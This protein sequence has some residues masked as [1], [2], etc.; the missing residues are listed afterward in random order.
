MG[1]PGGSVPRSVASMGLPS[2]PLLWPPSQ[3]SPEG[4]A[5]KGPVSSHTS[6]C[7]SRLPPLENAC[8]SCSGWPAVPPTPPILGTQPPLPC[9]AF[10]LVCMVRVSCL[11]VK[12]LGQAH[13]CGDTHLA[14]GLVLTEDFKALALPALAPLSLGLPLSR[15]PEAFSEHSA[16]PSG[17]CCP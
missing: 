16:Q 5:S 15:A 12:S 1:S 3:H 11:R 13:V 10:L 8:L 2:P 6:L 7:Q 4:L 9:I 14:H 17:A